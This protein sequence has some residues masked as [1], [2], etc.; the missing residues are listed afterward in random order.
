MR[1]V[2]AREI[3]IWDTDYFVEIVE[4]W[5]TWRVKAFSTVFSKNRHFAA[6]REMRNMI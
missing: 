6:A 5:W 3:T 4:T 1:N 2:K